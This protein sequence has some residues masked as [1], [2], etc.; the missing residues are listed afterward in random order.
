MSNVEKNV[1]KVGLAC[2]RQV[3]L[4]LYLRTLRWGM[5]PWTVRVLKIQMND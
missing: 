1:T 4:A 2:L 5:L 3:A